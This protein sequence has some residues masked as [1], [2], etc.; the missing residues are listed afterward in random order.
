MKEIQH[1]EATADTGVMFGFLSAGRGLG[2]VISGP[3]SEALL[4][5][6]TWQGEAGYG[7]YN[8]K[9]GSLIVLTGTT[10]AVGGLS[11]C[12]RRTGWM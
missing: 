2:A 9:Y 6:E 7:G 5:L 10:A 1:H 11:W 8:S 12:M 4:G 3:L